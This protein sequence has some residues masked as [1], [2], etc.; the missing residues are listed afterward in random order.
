MTE[1]WQNCWAAQLPGYVLSRHSSATTFRGYVHTHQHTESVKPDVCLLQVQDWTWAELQ[2]RTW[3]SGDPLLTVAEA[4]AQVQQFVDL[5]IVD[6]KASDDINRV[7]ACDT[8]LRAHCQRKGF[9][10]RSW[11]L[12]PCCG[13]GSRDMSAVQGRC[14]HA[15]TD[16]PQC[17]LL[18]VCLC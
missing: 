6:V 1:T 12:L 7:S 17:L 10:Q 5:L 2:D 14:W 4:V 11:Q 15:C 9:Q 13:R 16:Q 8:L 18:W 3:P